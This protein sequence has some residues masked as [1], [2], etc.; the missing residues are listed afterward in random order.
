MNDIIDMS[1][2]NALME[3]LENMEDEQLAA[4]LL[5][6]LND[7]TKDHGQLIINRDPNMSHAEWKVLSDE[8]KAQVDLVVNEIKSYKL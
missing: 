4:Q 2:M 8:A 7:K 1:E 3:I 6:K 5:K